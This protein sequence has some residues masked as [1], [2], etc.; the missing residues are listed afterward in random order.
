MTRYK[1]TKSYIGQRTS[2][3]AQGIY[4]KKYKEGSVVNAVPGTLGIMTFN[5]YSN[6]LQFVR[7][8]PAGSRFQI[9]KV[10]PIGKGKRIKFVSAGQHEERIRRF[11]KN[12]QLIEDERLIPEGASPAPKG[13]ICYQSVEVLE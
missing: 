9:V 2:M 7:G 13:T 8:R 11:Y 3:Y 12:Q 1:I 5:T 6:A 4:C 10:R